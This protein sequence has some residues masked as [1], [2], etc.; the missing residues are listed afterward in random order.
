MKRQ[1]TQTT[2]YA[3][4]RGFTLI[5]LLVVISIIALLIGILLPALGSARETA[6]TLIC[7]S[8]VRSMIQASVIIA[9]D[10]QHR[11]MFPNA[12]TI[13]GD[14][15]SHLFPLYIES[16]MDFIDG[17]FGNTFDAAICPSTQNIIH[18]DPNQ[19]FTRSDGRT[20]PFVASTPVVGRSGLN[21]LPLRDLYTNAHEGAD[22]ETGGHSYDIH[23]WAE[24]GKYRT[25]TVN[26]VAMTDNDY[27][28]PWNSG[29]SVSGARLKTDIWVRQTSNV[30]IIAENDAAGRYGMAD[31][32][33]IALGGNAKKID[34]HAGR[35]QNFGFMDGHVSFVSG[36]RE[37]VEVLLDAMV[38]FL[39]PSAGGRAR[40]GLSHVGITATNI[41]SNGVSIREYDY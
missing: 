16:K 4:M 14:N 17:I 24:F 20:G 1:T 10:E 22:D 5:E 13:Q 9:E 30:A 26:E 19:P 23:A 7:T 39:S 32:D 21:Y 41:I 28:T 11:I 18:T 6:R 33:Q 3:V 15:I 25:G 37:Q 38:D 2:L 40:A 34:N 31:E 35:G 29:D 8:N 36:D 12:D 27:Y